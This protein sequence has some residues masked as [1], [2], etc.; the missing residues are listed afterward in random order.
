MLFHQVA[1]GRQ[2]TRFE[3]VPQALNRKKSP[4][5]GFACRKIAA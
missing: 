2:F 4:H 3:H 5:A 1:D